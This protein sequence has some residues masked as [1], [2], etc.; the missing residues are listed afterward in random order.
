M[1]FRSRLRMFR[2]RLHD[3]WQRRSCSLLGLRSFS[4]KELLSSQKVGC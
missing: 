1:S 4:F 3:R 2:C